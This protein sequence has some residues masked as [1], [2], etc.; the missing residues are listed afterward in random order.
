[1]D[2]GEDAEAQLQPA[3]G[4]MRSAG[5]RGVV[6]VGQARSPVGC[7]AVSWS[8]SRQACGHGWADVF[9]VRG[10]APLWVRSQGPTQSGAAPRTPKKGQTTPALCLAALMAPPTVAT[11]APPGQV[12]SLTTATVQTSSCFATLARRRRMAVPSGLLAI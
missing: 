1:G 6:V 8:R 2:H 12:I 5:R 4:R 7:L 9:G 3:D 10:G 11:T